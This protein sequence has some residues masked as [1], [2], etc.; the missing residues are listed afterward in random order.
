MR[1]RYISGPLRAVFNS[2]I[3]EI[4]ILL[5]CLAV[6]AGTWI[7]IEIADEMVEGGAQQFDLRALEVLRT[8][9]PKWLTPVL[10]DITAL[11]SLSVLFLVTVSITGILF[12]RKDYRHMIFIITVTI[13]GGVLVTV[14]KMAFAR[15]RPDILLP[16]LLKETTPGFPSGHAAMSAAVYLSIAAVLARVLDSYKARLYV[17]SLSV[18]FTFLVGMTRVCLGVHYF[19][20]VLAGWAFG[21]AWAC[22]CWLVV[23]YLDARSKV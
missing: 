21:F 12:L 8:Y 6:V 13:C 2:I 17:I 4:G 15:E 19:T 23:R 10:R 7:F 11:G 5:A 20:D 14:L 1:L 9:H 18:A 22:F 3:K 16:T